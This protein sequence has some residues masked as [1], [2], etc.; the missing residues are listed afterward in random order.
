[1]TTE[2]PQ[3]T[4]LVKASAH[5]WSH[6]CYF[7][8]PNAFPPMPPQHTLC[9]RCGALIMTGDDDPMNTALRVCPPCDA[10]IEAELGVGLG[11][12]HDQ[13]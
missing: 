7:C 9:A 2:E 4:L 5:D 1:M 6:A 8:K 3:G 13:G 11:V 12:V 10:E